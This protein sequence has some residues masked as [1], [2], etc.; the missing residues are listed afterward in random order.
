M[1]GTAR[2]SFEKCAEN[3]NE[4]ESLPKTKKKKKLFNK[5]IFRWQY[6]VNAP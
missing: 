4:I 3:I 2:Q 6:F 5:H 1:Q